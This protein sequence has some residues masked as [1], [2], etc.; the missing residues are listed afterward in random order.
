MYRQKVVQ[1]PNA[2]QHTA[3]AI[4]KEVL[5]HPPPPKKGVP[6]RGRWS[7]RKN[8]LGDHFLSKMMI[9]QGVRRLI[10]YLGVC[11]PNNPKKGGVYN[12]RTC[13]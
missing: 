6:K 12:A 7:N 2:N 8:S 11:Y 9:F 13:D 1:D 4:H 3:A 5:T 10:P